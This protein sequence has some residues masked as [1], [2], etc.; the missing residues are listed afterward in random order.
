MSPKYTGSLSLEWYNKHKSVL[1]LSESETKLGD[2]PAPSLNWVN[3]EQSL[4]YEIVAEE[5]RGLKPYWV[6]RNDIRVRE[7]R[8]LVFQSIFQASAVDDP[9]KLPG[10][11]T[12]FVINEGCEEDYSIDNMLIK[13]DNLLA[14]NSLKKYFAFHPDMRPKCIFIDPP[15]NTG[16]AFANYDDNLELSTWLTLMRDRLVL[17]HEFLRKDGVIYVIL[18]DNATFYCKIL[19]DTIFGRENFLGDII[20]QSRKSVSN[21]THLSLATNH[22]LT[23]SR[24]IEALVKTDF[25]YEADTSTFSNP[26]NDP[27]GPWKLDPFD[28]PNIRPNL[29]YPITNP[30]TGKVYFPPQGRCWRTEEREFQRLMQDN[31]ILFGRGGISKPA[32]KRF[33][34][35]A[36]DR[37]TT[38][39]TLW[40]QDDL[41]RKS[42]VWNDIETNTNATDHLRTLF[43]ADVFSNPKPE[44]LL[45]RAIRLATDE[46]DVVLD[47]FAG[48]GTTLSVA[49][50]MRRKWIGVE[51][52]DQADNVIIPRLKLVLSGVDKNGVSSKHDYIGGGA[53]KFFHL[54]HSVLRILPDGSGD[55]NWEL[56]PEFIQESLLLSYDFQLI[57]KSLLSGQG[58]SFLGPFPSLGRLHLAS[59]LIIGICSLC[60]PDAAYDI[61]DFDEIMSLY[62]YGKVELKAKF[63]HIFTNRGISIATQ[64]KPADLEVFKVPHA[65]FNTN[66]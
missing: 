41:E 35:E 44:S 2:I 14:L 15:Y 31:R 19:M 55:L 17:L 25:R 56:G 65:I 23:Y 13:G 30:L 27:R 63:I 20:W 64:D 59:G 45:E 4:F 6:D 5:G 52:G 1:A 48:S 46:N 24:D 34:S 9:E 26:D 51:V 8:P 37:G 16:K 66:Q 12:S 3:K 57:P 43:G 36:E 58:I 42:N 47:I 61:I 40:R 54:G 33:A 29:T 50:K 49:H 22:I 18:D 7:S 60:P 32:L 10:M 11:D 28:A 53:F 39:T 38:P 21:D 62:N